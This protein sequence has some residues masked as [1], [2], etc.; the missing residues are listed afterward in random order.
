MTTEIIEKIKQDL[1]G[2][3][4][5][6]Q[7]ELLAAS[8]VKHLSHFDMNDAPADEVPKTDFLPSFIAAK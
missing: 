7:M 5:E 4:S 1:A 6:S 3:L 8:L 2:S